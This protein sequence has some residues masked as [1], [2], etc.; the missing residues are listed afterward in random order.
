MELALTYQD[1]LTRA[2]P[3][4]IRLMDRHLIGVFERDEHGR[5]AHFGSG[6]LVQLGSAHYVATAGHN[7]QENRRGLT[8][9]W[10]RTDSLAQCLEGPELLEA[11][12]P[13]PRFSYRV[14]GDDVDLGLILLRDPK[15]LLDSG[16]AFYKLDDLHGEPTWPH[17]SLLFLLGFPGRYVENKRVSRTPGGVYL[18]AQASLQQVQSIPIPCFSGLTQ[19]REDWFEMKVECRDPDPKNNHTL[20]YRGYSGGP[21]FRLRDVKGLDGDPSG[22]ELVGLE[23]S[24][25]RSTHYALLKS[26]YIHQWCSFAPTLEQQTEEERTSAHN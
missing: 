19:A 4:L 16:K 14:E 9:W 23:F 13:E 12:G 18:R 11:C 10:F 7:L 5:L 21:V 26:H 8:L 6:I 25:R 17:D 24:Q 22:F 15:R 1:I 3:A 2:N 20:D